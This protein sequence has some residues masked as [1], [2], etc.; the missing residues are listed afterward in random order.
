MNKLY[1]FDKIR[2]IFVSGTRLCN[3]KCP[4]CLVKKNADK[5][6]RA[7]NKKLLA[8]LD[9]LI[10]KFS[11]CFDPDLRITVTGGEALF[12]IDHTMNIINMFAKYSNNI[13][14]FT[15]GELLSD[16][17]RMSRVLTAS[18]NIGFTIGFDTSQKSVF[19]LDENQRNIIKE[20]AARKKV[21]GIFVVE[22]PEGIKDVAKNVK[23]ITELTG[24]SPRIEFDVFRLQELQLPGVLEK[25][26]EQLKECNYIAFPRGDADSKLCGVIYTRPDG[27]MWTCMSQVNRDYT[28]NKAAEFRNTKCAVCESRPWCRNCEVYIAQHHG[29]GYCKYVE[30]LSEGAR[31]AAKGN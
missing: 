14:I 28:Y 27:T 25:L 19:R 13:V 26:R 29:D 21:F 10:T 9:G 30:V 3:M 5:Y 7:D 8:Q 4:Y 6:T 23:E 31:N 20:L 1:M 15:N 22:G 2:E 11:S 12:D 17:E 24:V 16:K 18:P